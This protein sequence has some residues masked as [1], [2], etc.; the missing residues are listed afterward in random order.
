MKHLED[1]DKMVSTIVNSLAGSGR[2]HA[3][4]IVTGDHTTPVSYMDHTCEPVPFIVAPVSTEST[5]KCLQAFGS[6]E[7]QAFNEVEIGMRGSLGRF[8]GV[9]IMSIVKSYLELM[10]VCD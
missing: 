4:I 7:V 8:P 10:D 5:C 9:A 6:D 2:A 3:G 1:V